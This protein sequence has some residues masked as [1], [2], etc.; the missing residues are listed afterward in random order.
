[1]ICVCTHVLQPR[2]LPIVELC[3]VYAMLFVH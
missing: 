3:N 2:E 1:M